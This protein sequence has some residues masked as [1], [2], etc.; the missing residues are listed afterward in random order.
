MKFSPT[1]L[2]VLRTQS[3]M[4][5]ADLPDAVRIPALAPNRPDDVTRPLTEAT[6]DDIAFGIQ[7]LEAESRAIHARLSA[8][9]EL[10]DRA[11]K[12]GALGVTTV[13]E[14]FAGLIHG[15]ARS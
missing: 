7:G 3:S 9:R 15:E 12:R 6:V 1:L 10:H 4:Y 8:L 14:A 5:L 13:A 2:D 11:R